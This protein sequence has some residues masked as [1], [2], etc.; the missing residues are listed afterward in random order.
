MAMFVREPFRAQAGISLIQRTSVS[1]GGIVNRLW[2]EPIFPAPVER[3]VLFFKM[4]IKVLIVQK[5]A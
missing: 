5:L 4:Q 3:Q 1:C 2:P